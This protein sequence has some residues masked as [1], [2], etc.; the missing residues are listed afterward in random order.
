MTVNVEQPFED[1]TAIDVITEYFIPFAF[2]EPTDVWAVVTDPNDPDLVPLEVQ[3]NATRITGSIFELGA[4]VAGRNVR[5]ERRTPIEQVLSL[6]PGDP[7]PTNNLEREL[8]RQTLVNQEQA[9]GVEGLRVEVSGLTDDLDAATAA[10]EAAAAAAAVSE[11]DAASAAATATTAVG[12]ANAAAA[13]AAASEAAAQAALQSFDNTYLGPKASDPAVDNLGN[14][15]TAGDLYLNTTDGLMKYYDGATWQSLSP[16][17]ASADVFGLYLGNSP[18]NPTEDLNGDPLVDGRFYL[19][20]NTTVNNFRRYDGLAL[21]TDI[22]SGGAGVGVGVGNGV[23]VDAGAVTSPTSTDLSNKFLIEKAAGGGGQLVVVAPGSATGT[24][25]SMLQIVDRKDNNAATNALTMG[26][27]T[28]VPDEMRIHAGRISGNDFGAFL[29]IGAGSR[30]PFKIEQSNP[31]RVKISRFGNEFNPPFGDSS[32]LL[33]QAG[34]SVAQSALTLQNPQTNATAGVSLKYSV[35]LN[36]QGGFEQRQ[37]D[38]FHYMYAAGA[39]NTTYTPQFGCTPS[40]GSMTIL[41]G[42]TGTAVP[43]STDWDR[44]TTDPALRVHYP[45]SNSGSGPKIYLTRGSNGG[46]FMTMEHFIGG[47]VIRWAATSSSTPTTLSL[48]GSS[49]YPGADNT[50]SLGFAANRWTEVFSVNGTINTSDMRSKVDVEA[51][52]VGLAEVKQMAAISHRWRDGKAGAGKRYS[53]NAQQLQKL[54]KDKDASPVV[55]ADDEAQTLGLNAEQM[56]P[57][58]VNAIKE[59]SAKVDELESK[60]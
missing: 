31:W 14:P 29:R 9:A 23:V 32:G 56:I 19:Y 42:L 16:G 41:N 37:L 46:G 12:D 8:D 54:F 15:L 44:V 58:L 17:G 27:N 33:V 35:G 30:Y 60:R 28:S 59:L 45:A 6:Q 57:I 20:F 21:W 53:L 25:L 1:Y 10:A 26:F 52:D 13:A 18:G 22:A 51:A 47:G 38:G 2:L 5:I 40:R 34:S 3:G 7:Q 36:N 24:G 55:V 50:L 39:G 48:G 49:V 11:A 43:S 4:V